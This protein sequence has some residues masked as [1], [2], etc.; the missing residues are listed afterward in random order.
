MNAGLLPSCT[1]G[2]QSP[3]DSEA[4]FGLLPVLPDAHSGLQ[5]LC[6]CSQTPIVTSLS[7]TLQGY[8]SSVW[9]SACLP[10]SSGH[11][12]LYFLPLQTGG[13][14]P[15]IRRLILDSFQAFAMRPLVSLPMPHW[16]SWWFLSPDSPVELH[17]SPLTSKHP[18]EVIGKRMTREGSK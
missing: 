4:A 17:L 7:G 13:S 1:T 2:V 10:C 6:R 12:G 8:S 5:G 15:A 14:L 3:K 9:F 11:S 18:P 16:L